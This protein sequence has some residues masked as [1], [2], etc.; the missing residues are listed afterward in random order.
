LGAATTIGLGAASKRY[1]I[2]TNG[3]SNS[4]TITGNVVTCAARGM[5]GIEN[6]KL[7]MENEFTMYPNPTHSRFTIHDLPFIGAGSIVVTD[8][9][10]KQVKVQSLSMGTNTMDVSTLSKGMYFVS[11]IKM[12][13]K[14]PRN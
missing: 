1:T 8:L 13:E 10:G 2:T 9:Y 7:K 5:N 14:Q 4:R 3:C 11:T 12:K 6:G